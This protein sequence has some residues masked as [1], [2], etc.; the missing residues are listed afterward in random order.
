MREVLREYKTLDQRVDFDQSGHRVVEFAHASYDPYNVDKSQTEKYKI[1]VLQMT[2]DAVRGV[3]DRD[4]KYVNKMASTIPGYKSVALE[5]LPSEVVKQLRSAASRGVEVNIPTLVN[6]FQDRSE[7]HRFMEQVTKAWI[8]YRALER[9]IE[10]VEG[11][12][13]PPID[14]I[15]KKGND[16]DPQH[17]ENA[18]LREAA[19]T[20]NA[21][22]LGSHLQDHE[23]RLLYV[24]SLSCLQNTYDSPT[25]QEARVT[26]L[27]GDYLASSGQ[28]QIVVGDP[29]SVHEDKDS[30][31]RL[32][33]RDF[34]R[35]RQVISAD[36]QYK[37][38]LRL[39]T[40]EPTPLPTSPPLTKAA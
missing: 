34:W 35:N 4:D 3:R 9:G 5:G 2:L 37:R 39:L 22:V 15:D 36:A 29:Y 1:A 31:K 20:H 14:K 8:A 32:E 25:L 7:P 23:G 10:V 33:N 28:S 19:Y 24:A 40:P 12:E 30:I 11:L 26:T 16:I 13:Q 38:N 17:Q 21:M 6:S 18:Q 27:V